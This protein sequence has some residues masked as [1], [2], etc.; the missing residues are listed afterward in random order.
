MTETPAPRRRRPL[1]RLLAILGLAAALAVAGLWL[2]R[3]AVVREVL[4]GW[5]RSRGVAAQAEV[6]AFDPSR[7]RAR[8]RLGDPARPDFAAED[9]DIRYRLTMHGP[10][11]TSIE[12]TRPTLKASFHEG[13]LSLGRLDPIVREVLSRPAGPMPQVTI[14]G[15]RLDLATDYGPVSLTSDAAV[16]A[17]RLKSLSAVSA[18]MRLKGRGLALDLGQGV[19]N[20]VVTGG[21]LEA[22][23]DAPAAS[24][25]FGGARAQ[26]ARVALAVQ[27]PYPDLA[28]RTADGA[29]TLEA[30]LAAASLTLDGRRLEDADLS[31][32]FTGRQSG[33]LDDPRRTGRADGDLTLSAKV[34]AATQPALRMDRVS[35]AAQGPAAWT[36][37]G[38][39]GDLTGG[40]SGHGDWR[41]LDGMA[42]DGSPELAAVKRAARGFSI[43][44]PKVRLALGPEGPTI[45]LPAPVRIAPDRGGLI[46]ASAHGDRPVFAPGGGAF[47]LAL[48]GGGL[49][50]AT[51]DVERLA[52]ARDGRV[53]VAG[54]LRGGLSIGPARDARLDASGVLRAAAGGL[55]FTA[56]RCVT[57]S[58]GRLELGAN[59]I[60]E[61][62]GR[63][64]PAG[65]VMIELKGG[66]WRV[67]G[68][69]E[70][71]A[72]AVPFAQVRLDG[73]AGAI[74]ASSQGARLA[75]AIA[76]DQARVRDMSARPR[77]NPLIAT[78]QASLTGDVWRAD[79]DARLPSGPHVAH[80]HLVHDSLTGG[81]VAID[82]G[83]LV[84][85]ANGLQPGAIS[86][87]T[88]AVGSPATGRVRFD[89]RF[90]W[91]TQGATSSGSLSIDGLD[92]QSPAGRVEGL[93][94][95][96]VF[97]SLAP[98]DAEPG[99][100]LHIDRLGAIVP[101]TDVTARFALAASGLRI[102]GGEAGV[103]GGKV[104]V[105][106]LDVPFDP[107][108][109]MKGVL[110][111]DRVQL[112]DIVE[113]SPFGDRVDL[114][115]RVSGTVP[116]EATGE[117]VRITGGQLKAV[118]PGRLR[119]DRAALTGVKAAGALAA[120]GV[121]E[122][123]SP[124]DTFTDFA[125]QAMENLAFDTLE[126]SIASRPDGRLGVLFHI[127]GRHDPPTHQE[128]RLSAMDLV[129]RSF[130]GR[131]LPLPS[132][133]GVNLTL[134]TTLNLDDLLSDY[135]DFR[136]LHGSGAVQP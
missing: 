136:R 14:K 57:A 69:A 83:D 67:A 93:S 47:T 86:P 58:M 5:L 108:Q 53:T 66:A 123:V 94:G 8:L 50:D 101:V 102:A 29:I 107:A 32:T 12:L 38:L 39:T 90:D 51:A 73:G 131:K 97:A 113:A 88:S 82:T 98:L 42:D 78:G 130:L 60:D 76:V 25:E 77:F 71:V 87:L 129:R 134:D 55:A 127:V 81:G 75:A 121:T 104:R 17:G 117:K 15:G 45:R 116:F 19:L 1:L 84:F 132:G 85:A 115:A 110:F 24:A 72:A 4:T 2:A 62:S 91:A 34:K 135:V 92:F 122:P 11:V 9:A 48:S 44:A 20:V 118:E 74:E 111:F 126:A 65:G 26:D 63:L 16:E 31:A 124:N 30:R 23:L 80:L 35:L 43:S 33:W 27:A 13:K 114:D 106:S 18:P 28:R 37:A 112:H 61:V 99:Q 56:D 41:G 96:L 10:Q 95:E 103:G 128:I 7:F 133:T 89:G 64:C 36:P 52:Q 68:R 22:R 120:P 109:P 59:D 6:E 49:P 100:A 54:R 119:I 79:L 46:Q 3:K 21:R 40:I 70:D 125:Y 105:E